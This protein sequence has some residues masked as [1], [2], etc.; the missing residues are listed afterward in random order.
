MHCG[1]NLWE[2]NPKTMRTWMNEVLQL[3]LQFTDLLMRKVFRKS[4]Y[5]INNRQRTWVDCS[6]K[7]FR[8]RS[9]YWDCSESGWLSTWLIVLQTN[10]DLPLLSHKGWSFATLYFFCLMYYQLS[11]YKVCCLSKIK[12]KSLL[13][14]LFLD[15]R[16]RV[17]WVVLIMFVCHNL[18][19]LQW[20]LSWPAPHNVH[21]SII[22]AIVTNK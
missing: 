2:N 19:S 12:K 10:N 1:A 13:C 4:I 18:L 8:Q 21:S 14:W 11:L 17:E 16:M 3:F 22:N 7:V 15:D 6:A 5:I 20:V 9:L